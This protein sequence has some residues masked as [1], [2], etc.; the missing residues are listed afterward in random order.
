MITMLISER[1]DAKTMLELNILTP[2]ISISQAWVP[3]KA[4][5]ESN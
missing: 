3:G 4:M 2:I 5:T 1:I